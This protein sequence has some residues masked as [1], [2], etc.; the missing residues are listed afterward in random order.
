M[1]EK[2]IVYLASHI[3]PAHTGGEQYNLHLIAAAEKAGV[4]VVQE[5]LSD[6]FVHRWLS[7]THLLW[8]LCRIYAF[9]WLHMKIFHH[10]REIL[11]FDAWLSPL[12]WPSMMLVRGHYLVMVHHL[13]AGLRE[14]PWRR[15]WEGFCEAQLLR[16][17]RRVL[18][19]SRSS[20]QQIEARVSGATPIDIIH[21]AFEPVTGISHGGGEVLRI[22]YV[23]HITRAKGVID[24]VQAISRLPHNRKWR[25]DMVGRNT[26]EPD[27][28]QHI[29]EICRK[30]GL[31]DR[32]FLH[33]R[34]D[35]AALQA[36]YL[37]SDI[38]VLPSHWE[39]Y[40]IVLLEAMSHRVA[41]VSTTAGA[42]P[43][44]VADGETGLLVTPG[45]IPALH[46]ALVSL[47]DNERLR[48][49]LAE[50]GHIYARKHADWQDMEA[51][52]RQWWNSVNLHLDGE[53]SQKKSIISAIKQCLLRLLM[54]RMAGTKTRSMAGDIRSIALWQF[55]GVGDMLLA[56][57][58]I[59]AL[60]KTYPEA[61][62]HLWC[63]NPLFAGFL[64]HFSQVKSIHSFPVYDFDSRTLMHSRVR[65]QIKQLSDAMAA[66]NVDLL[67]NL[68][69][70]ALLDWWV[71]EWWLIKRLAV[72]YALGFDPRFL[73][74]KSIFDISLEVPLLNRIHY[75][76]L[77][78]R[79]L[80][81]AGID[82]DECTTFPLSDASRKHALQLL[83]NCNLSGNRWICMHMGGERLKLENKMWP[84]ERFASLA[85]QLMK[86][87]F[88][89]VL[90]GVQSECPMGDELSIG[91][92]G[93][94][95]LIGR[96]ELE[97]MA[98]L[99]E[100]ADGFVGHDS[101]PFHIAVAVGTPCVGICGRPD[102]EPEYLQYDRH[103][104]AV[105]IRD[106]PDMIT[107]ESVYDVSM[108]I[109][110]SGQKADPVIPTIES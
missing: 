31:H 30:E 8:R 37:G 1:T 65:E 108:D 99:I 92:S 88:T 84:V 13:C 46:K 100:Q 69:I 6:S 16:G 109:F 12:L 68:H 83:V 44:V 103:D 60:E 35:D 47:M 2:S 51:Q 62:I 91:V 75:T 23:G 34:I 89:I 78:Q 52:C 94:I 43:E 5:A 107:V 93:C 77:Y 90:L 9:L 76:R 18:T 59:L 101:G 98:A 3:E 40:G 80:K 25:L 17:A 45:D 63:S 26:V 106:T 97:D 55:G 66:Q 28:T 104:V 22:L 20:K 105:I 4:K 79:L 73:D 27:T 11:L 29:E 87:G 71:V 42:I 7:N 33:G 70:P 38:F 61:D 54:R 57:P 14:Q 56:T 41:V 81:D 50:N 110:G 39:G 95:N 36:L 32:V 74:G 64:Q 49:N 15:Q 102:A 85:T 72:P 67:I 86:A 96:T 19:V 53:S 48:E 82:G 10:R 58:V 24:L 21:P